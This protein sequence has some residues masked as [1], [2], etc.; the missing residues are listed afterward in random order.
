MSQATIG[1]Q[2]GAQKYTEIIVFASNEA[3]DQFRSGNFAFDSQAKVGRG[4]PVRLNLRRINCR[5]TP[6]RPT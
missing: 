2:L 5:T 4:Q 3:L 1:F 6:A